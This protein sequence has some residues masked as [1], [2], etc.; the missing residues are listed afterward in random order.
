MQIFGSN[1]GP[2]SSQQHAESV[3]FVINQLP[4]PDR[5]L[6]YQIALDKINC[7][8][9]AN[10]VVRAFGHKWRPVKKPTDGFFVV[11]VAGVR[12]L[13]AVQNKDNEDLPA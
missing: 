3:L 5:A 1:V 7:C 11:T 13:R 2:V 4:W 6:A 10:K 8:R 12:A 9:I